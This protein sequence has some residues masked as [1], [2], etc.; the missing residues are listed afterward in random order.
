M[1]IVETT[2]DRVINPMI[3]DKIHEF[4]GRGLGLSGREVIRASR[5][6]GRS[7]KSGAPVD[8]GLV[9]EVVGVELERVRE[10]L[11][12]GIVAVISPVGVDETG[13]VLNINADVAAGAIASGLYARPSSF[14]SATCAESCAIPRRRIRLFPSVNRELIGKLIQDEIIEGGMIPKVES[15]AAALAQGVGKAHFIDGRVAHALLLE[16]FTQSGIGTEI[17]S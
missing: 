2:L 16:I 9:G 8:L 4:D 13:T 10:A 17:V 6:A 11:A 15:A 7:D 1:A 14:T 12:Q 5:V 3:V